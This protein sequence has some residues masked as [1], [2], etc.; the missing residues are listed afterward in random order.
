MTDIATWLADGFSAAALAVACGA[1]MWT[2]AQAVESRRQR[3]IAAQRHH[4]DRDPSPEFGQF[5]MHV[6]ASNLSNFDLRVLVTVKQDCLVS[7][8][9]SSPTERKLLSVGLPG[10]DWTNWSRVPMLLRQ[11]IPTPVQVADNLA[12]DNL[13]DWLVQLGFWPP[14]KSQP[15]PTWTC[16]CDRPETPPT[17]HWLQSTQIP[18]LKGLPRALT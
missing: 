2:R 5:S 3:E 4:L 15:V 11:G 1:A 12:D 8:R 6:N 16:G 14:G 18:P 7:T 13:S 10:I 9:L 17:P